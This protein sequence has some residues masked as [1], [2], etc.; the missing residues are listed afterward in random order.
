GGS[1]HGLAIAQTLAT[2]GLR[3]AVADLNPDRA[4]AAAQIIVQAGGTA[5]GIQADVSNKFQV[6]AMIEQTRDA[7]N[8]LDI[9]I[10]NA[11]VSPGDAALTMDEWNWRRTIEVNLTG[12]FFCAQ[13]AARV[14]ADESGG[15]IVLLTRRERS[16][17]GA[18][19]QA[20][21]EALAATMDR[22]LPDV[23]VNAV[24]ATDTDALL[25]CL[26]ISR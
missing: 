21:I 5:V 6:A 17:A 20:A 23:H 2:A 10:N 24:P 18:A 16:A 11:H 3:V 1:G 13:L 12:A 26:E 9:L 15:H 4:E 8:R 7:Y 22:D 25:Q 19:T 14:M